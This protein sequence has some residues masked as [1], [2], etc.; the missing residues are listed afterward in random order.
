VVSKTCSRAD[1]SSTIGAQRHER[2]P[3]ERATHL[4]GYREQ[5]LITQVGDLTLA[6][7]RFRQGSFFP[8]WLE[9]RRRV[10]KALYAVVMEASPWHLHSQG[11]R[12][13]RG[14]PGLTPLCR[15]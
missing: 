10:D 4:N 7:P 6:I 14:P 2:C 13:G 11:G 8:N 15:G 3:E 12:P 9:Q 5:L 1:V